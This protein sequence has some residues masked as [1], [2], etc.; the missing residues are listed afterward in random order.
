MH[1][2]QE[3]L[4]ANAHTVPRLLEKRIILTF[5]NRSLSPG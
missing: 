3:I 1:H 4:D 5:Q 2:N